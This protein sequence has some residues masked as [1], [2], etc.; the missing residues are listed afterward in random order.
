MI[1]DLH[2]HSNTSDG[3]LDVED[4]IF[5]SKKTGL[6]YVAITDHNIFNSK[7][8]LF[9]LEKKYEIKIIFA[10]EFSCFD[11]ARN[12]KVH[13][14]CYNPVNEEILLP[15]CEKSTKIRIEVGLKKAEYVKN[16]F[17]ISQKLIE[18]YR[19]KSGCIYQQNLAHAL[20]ECGYTDSIYGDL[21]ESLSSK[22]LKIEVEPDFDVRKVLGVI[23]KSGGKSVI[24]HPGVYDSFELI[25]ELVAENLI[26][27]LEVWHP[28]NSE[29]EVNK[30]LN[31]VQSYDLIAT[32]GTDFHGFYSSRYF[33]RIGNFVT[34]DVYLKKLIS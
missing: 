32:G 7:F 24:A 34:P 16:N 11:Y 6:D 20:L 10:A 29:L 23:K 17:F 5:I 33:S 4:L 13:V 31:L 25:N 9:K 8:E 19:S 21:Y 28:K 22:N 15:I 2:M 12:R 30:L 14:L 3:S 27:G 26:D 18:K 1:G